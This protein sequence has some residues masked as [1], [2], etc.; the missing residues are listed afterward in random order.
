MIIVVIII[1]GAGVTAYFVLSN[2][3]GNDSDDGDDTTPALGGPGLKPNDVLNY[4][5]SVSVYAKSGVVTYDDDKAVNGSFT[6]KFTPESSGDYTVTFTPD[7][8]YDFAGMEGT[9]DEVLMFTVSDLDMGEYGNDAADLAD[10][11][12][13]GY[14]ADEIE[15]I[16][17]L[18]D[19]FTTE[20]VT[21]STINGSISAEKRSF[22]FDWSDIMSLM[23]SG[24]EEDV[25]VIEDLI[26]TMDMW[27][28]KDI[29]YKAAFSI[30]ITTAEGTEVEEMT[31]SGAIE[32]IQ[33]QK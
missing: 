9:L 3:S 12:E 1:A 13:L 26:F 23:P 17:A 27:F 18:I 14:T 4:R 10:L 20:T 16:Q 32:L 33:H 29:L 15:K 6:L 5:I 25:G 19:K 11:S 22:S 28:G 8:T 21:L 30:S 7:I 2:N 31:I 24:Y